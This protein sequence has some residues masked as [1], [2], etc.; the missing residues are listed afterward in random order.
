MCGIAGYVRFDGQSPERSLLEGMVAA[1]KH[2]GPDAQTVHLD[3]PVG[4]GHA[5]LSII[6][7][8]GG[9]QPL[10]NEDETI[11]VI[12]NGE[13]YNYRELRNR[14]LQR[15]HRFRTGSDC[16]VI[17]HLWEDLG[18][19][20]VHELRGMF[21]FLLYDR[22]T[23]TIFA[24][25]DRFGQK[26]FYY[27][28][29][30]RSIAF[31]SEIKGLLALPE[32][33]RE[34]NPAALDQ[35]LFRSYVPHPRT[36]FAQVQ[37]LPAGNCLEFSLPGEVS[38]GCGVPEVSIQ[39]YWRPQL[40]P[41]L[42]VSAEEHLQRV[43]HAVTDAIQS[44][45][46]ADVPVGV[47]LSGGIDSSLIAAV[48]AKHCEQP[49]QTF[50]I[51]FPGSRHDE[52][53]HAR[54]VARAVGSRHFEF[55]FQAID[56]PAALTEAA[57]LFDQPVADAAILPLLALSREA[58]RQ[59]KVVLTGDGGDE[60]FAGYRKFKRLAGFPGRLGW[61][62]RATSQWLS[63]D[64]LTH[65]VPDPLGLRKFRARLAEAASPVCRSSY[66]RQGWEGW[67]RFGLYQPDLFQT[68]SDG[69]VDRVLH[70][71]MTALSSLAPLNAALHLEQET[72]L[73]DRL[74][75]KADYAT[76][77]HGLEA[78]A[79][80][81]DHH[82]AETAGRLP[83][84][85]KAT[86]ATTKV[87]LRKIAAQHLPAEIVQRVKKGFSL[88]LDQWL[89]NDLQEFTHRCLLEESVSQP[90]FFRRPAVERLLAE[91]ASGQDHSQRIYSLLMLELWC[92]Q[93][94]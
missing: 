89:R 22:R 34:L 9:T 70:D 17:A 26:P 21:A 86:P 40:A 61:L 4:F 12:C 27:H 75:L 16:E 25:R 59:V 83:V 77:A 46:V 73:A 38:A 14:L 69:P 6:D 7:L 15:G 51:A 81:L 2:R 87:A 41:D 64:E 85:L 30:P 65:C 23:R 44:H 33:S 47:F 94:L 57:T 82:L 52:S 5:R 67:E 88:P 8:A 91:H 36:M 45:L 60:L 92:R 68:I 39:S 1:M 42:S 74:L 84:E 76:M 63:I 11:T 72:V 3:G 58:S 48:A 31:A 19:N 66:H 35:F 13:I 90:R 93:Y 28:L 24:A 29:G 20:L 79:P 50:S 80:F 62:S 53:S 56:L 18:R 71:R 49:L 10:F 43:D 37:T 32:V 78:R 55:P 54:E